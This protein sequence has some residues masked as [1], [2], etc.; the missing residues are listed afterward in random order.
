[1]PDDLSGMVEEFEWALSQENAR[2]KGLP[3]N[4]RLLQYPGPEPYSRE[5]ALV[6][7]ETLIELDVPKE[8]YHPL[9]RMIVLP[10]AR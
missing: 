2:R 9:P 6:V 8:N 10:R 7:F 3:P 4:A 5:N 1:M